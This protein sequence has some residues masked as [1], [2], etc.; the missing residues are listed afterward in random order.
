[1]RFE[2]MEYFSTGISRLVLNIKS[3]FRC[4]WLLVLSQ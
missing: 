2:V 1:M 3:G 4:S